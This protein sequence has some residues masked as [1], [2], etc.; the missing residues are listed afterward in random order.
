[1]EQLSLFTRKS[2]IQRTTME[3]ALNDLY[4]EYKETWEY[5]KLKDI[6][7]MEKMLIEQGYSITGVDN[8]NGELIYLEVSDLKESTNTITQRLKSKSCK[9]EELSTNEIIQKIRSSKY[10]Y[11]KFIFNSRTKDL[12]VVYGYHLNNEGR[13]SLAN[14]YKVAKYTLDKENNEFIPKLSDW[15][16]SSYIFITDSAKEILNILNKNKTL[17]D[18]LYK[19]L[20][21]INNMG[22]EKFIQTAISNSKK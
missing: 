21:S 16:E 15:E 18:A 10:N 20:N 4:K 13:I 12:G 6:L 19:K 11:G 14:R 2:F 1:M 5:G 22:T 8:K 7:A 17:N 9:I 3:T